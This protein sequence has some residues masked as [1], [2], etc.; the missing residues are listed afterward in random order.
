MG[1]GQIDLHIPH[2]CY[3]LQANDVGHVWVPCVMC[4]QDNGLSIH[5]TLAVVNYGANA[6]FHNQDQALAFIAGCVA[7]EAQTWP[8]VKHG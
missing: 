1:K 2:C 5:T 7:R 4:Q 6:G 8:E 3:C